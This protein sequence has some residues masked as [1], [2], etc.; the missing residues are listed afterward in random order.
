MFNEAKNR[1][2]ILASGKEHC[3][4]NA[5]SDVG[6]LRIQNWRKNEALPFLTSFLCH[7]FTYMIFVIK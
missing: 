3:S 2:R 5:E 7:L 6:E 4:L 1:K